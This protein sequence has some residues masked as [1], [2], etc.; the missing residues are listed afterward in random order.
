M[1]FYNTLMGQPCPSA[2]SQIALTAPSNEAAEV[3]QSFA[4]GSSISSVAPLWLLCGSS[5]APL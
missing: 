1:C 3:L 5:V 2:V 4:Y